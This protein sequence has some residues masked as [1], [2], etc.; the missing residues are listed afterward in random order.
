MDVDESEARLFT[1]VQREYKVL[2]F[3]P[4]ILSQPFYSCFRSQFRSKQCDSK[5]SSLWY[6]WPAE[7]PAWKLSTISKLYIAARQNDLQKCLG[8]LSKSRNS[9]HSSLIS[10]P[11]LYGPNTYQ[12]PTPT[13][14]RPRLHRRL[15]L[16]NH[17]PEQPK[18]VSSPACRFPHG[19]EHQPR[20][21]QSSLV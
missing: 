20:F 12:L 17:R 16:P 1:R 2:Y 11:K 18:L 21:L 7:L 3:V 15:N 14:N 9:Q 10:R 6:I 13:V 4:F 5:S 8:H 19:M